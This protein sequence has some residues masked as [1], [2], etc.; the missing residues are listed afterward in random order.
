[1]YYLFNGFLRGATAG[2]AFVFSLIGIVSALET[3]MNKAGILD[4]STSNFGSAPFAFLGLVLGGSS[5][6][7][8]FTV[9][10]NMV[11]EKQVYSA[12]CILGIIVGLPVGLYAGGYGGIF[13]DVAI[14]CGITTECFG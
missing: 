6:I 5:A 8:V 7:W 9:I 4:T 12:P 10:G 13:F 2:F 14:N 1:M 11:D 3:Y